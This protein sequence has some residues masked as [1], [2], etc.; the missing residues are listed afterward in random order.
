[1]IFIRGAEL[2]RSNINLWTISV[3]SNVGDIP[4]SGSLDSSDPRTRLS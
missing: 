3:L 4:Y 2:I 1:M